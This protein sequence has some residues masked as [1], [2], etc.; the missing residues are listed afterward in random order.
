MKR[1]GG[2]FSTGSFCRSTGCPGTP[3]AVGIV[4][5]AAAG[6]EL[7]LARA[8]QF[9]ASPAG[10]NLGVEHIALVAAFGFSRPAQ[11]KYFAQIAGGHI[12]P[13]RRSFGESRDLGGAGLQQIDEPIFAGDGEN[14]AAVSRAGQQASCRNRKPG[15]TP[16]PRAK[17]RRAWASRR[18]RSGKFPNRR[19]R[20]A[21]GKRDAAHQGGR[22][23]DSD[24]DTT[25]PGCAA[26]PVGA[27]IGVVTG[28]GKSRRRG[29]RHVFLPR[30]RHKYFPPCRWPAP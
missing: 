5:V 16:G 9:G 7:D 25:M 24:S 15:R 18:A 19:W 22:R 13:A 28:A 20:S 14:M 6:K 29:A 27:G 10:E 26:P 17:S 1:A 12:K 2:T 30:R 23:S 3:V 21:P 11:Q 8:A 4:H